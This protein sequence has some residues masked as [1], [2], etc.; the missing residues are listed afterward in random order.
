MASEISTAQVAARIALGFVVIC[1]AFFGP[2][3]TIK[4]PEAWI[5][6]VTQFSFSTAM[7]VWL[8]KNNPG[9]L[10]ERLTLVKRSAREWDKV[11]LAIST[12]IFIPYMLLPG[13]DAV[14]YGW[15]QVPFLLKIAAFAGI[16]FSLV[17]V[18]WIMRVNTFLSRFAE[19]QRDRGHRVITEGPYRYIRHPM[20]AA[21]IVLIISIPLLLGSLWSLIPGGMMIILIIIRTALEDRMLQAELDGYRSYAD[22]VRYR[23]LPG[24][25]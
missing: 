24:L 10:R 20:Y 5:Y 9:L 16:I 21:I 25:W 13:F 12:V 2:A 4:W 23:L 6:I 18:F 15:S 7:A 11:I 17:V 8:K 1:A 22:K 14:R 3:G 19:I